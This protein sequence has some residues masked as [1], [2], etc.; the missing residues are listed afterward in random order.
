MGTCNTTLP[1]MNTATSSSAAC[2]SNP[3]CSPN[4]GNS[5]RSAD[6]TKPATRAAS[7]TMGAVL[8]APDSPRS[9]VNSAAEADREAEAGCGERKKGC[10]QDHR[11]QTRGSQGD[12]RKSRI[13]HQTQLERYQRRLKAEDMAHPKAAGK[14]RRED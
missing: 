3:E 14:G 13:G 8:N 2:S 10:A 4:S 6:S 1:A 5:V 9:G 7:I 11:N 12:D